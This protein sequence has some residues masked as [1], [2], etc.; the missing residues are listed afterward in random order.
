MPRLKEWLSERPGAAAI[1][2]D[3]QRAAATA[4]SKAFNPRTEVSA[5]AKYVVRNLVLWFLVL[6]ALL[7]LLIW[8]VANS[9]K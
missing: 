7:S 2:A 3:E 9:L 8:G 5:D 4:A 1:E 6:P